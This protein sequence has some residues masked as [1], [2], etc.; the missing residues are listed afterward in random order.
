MSRMPSPSHP[1]RSPRRRSIQLN[2]AL[3]AYAQATRQPLYVLL[4]LFPIVATYEFGALILRPATMPERDL[5]AQSLIQT[6]LSFLGATGYLVPGVLLLLTLLIWHILSGRNWSVLGWVFPLMLLESIL[7]TA[8]LF[9]LG[10]LALQAET[11]VSLRNQ[12]V[13]AL[14]AGIYEEMVFRLLL[15]TGLML[16]FEEFIN[17]PRTIAAAAAIGLAALV[18]AACHVLPIGAE[19]FAWP[20]FLMRSAAGAYLALV[21]LTRGLGI[22]VGCHAAYNLILLLL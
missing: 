5:V 2:A 16:L 13:L 20:I 3:T 4:F 9:V 6:A 1:A 18:F 10:R 11:G 8:P 17:L 22:S 12:V 14:G 19:P 7:L 15:V 21:F